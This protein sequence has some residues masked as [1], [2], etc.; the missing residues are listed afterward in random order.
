MSEKK[1][2]PLD[3]TNVCWQWRDTWGNTLGGFATGDAGGEQ[4]WEVF[5]ILKACKGKTLTFVIDRLT[6]PQPTDYYHFVSK[7]EW[8]KYVLWTREQE[9]A[10]HG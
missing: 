8:E 9:E 4:A 5:K 2:Y 7:D 3:F 6:L 10:R 1:E